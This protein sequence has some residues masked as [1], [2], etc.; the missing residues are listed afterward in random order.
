M[1]FPCEHCEG[2]GEHV[3]PHISG[4]PQREYPVPCPECRGNCKQRCANDSR[5]AIV[6]AWWVEKPGDRHAQLDYLCAECLAEHNHEKL[7]VKVEEVSLPEP[8]WLAVAS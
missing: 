4:D 7:I 6:R 5:V 8:K 1:S 2:S 3:L